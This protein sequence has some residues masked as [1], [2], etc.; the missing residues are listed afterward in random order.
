MSFPTSPT[1]GQQVIIG[2]RTWRWDGSVWAVVEPAA[3]PT[4]ALLD[5]AP[6]ISTPE[7][8]VPGNTVLDRSAYPE[9]AE[10]VP[11]SYD[12]TPNQVNSN[13]TTTGKWAGNRYCRSPNLMAFWRG[14]IYEA[15][16]R[17]LRGLVRIDYPIVDGVETGANVTNGD[18][19]SVGG[20]EGAVLL[21]VVN[22]E[23]YLITSAAQIF[24]KPNP[25][26][27]WVKVGDLDLS[28]LNGG[29][30]PTYGASL[31]CGYLK[32]GKL[33]VGWKFRTRTPNDR[34]SIGISR[35]DGITTGP[36]EQIH[37]IQGSSTY[38]RE[39]GGVYAFGP[40]HEGHVS[41]IFHNVEDAYSNN[42]LDSRVVP[43][44]DLSQTFFTSSYSGIAWV[45]GLRV[46]VSARQEG[47]GDQF[48]VYDVDNRQQSNG[49]MSNGHQFGDGSSL[50]GICFGY[51]NI[52]AFFNDADNYIYWTED[53]GQTWERTSRSSSPATQ[54]FYQTP[55]NDTVVNMP[56][57]GDLDK[58]NGVLLSTEGTRVW[59]GKFSSFDP[60]QS[61]LTPNVGPNKIIKV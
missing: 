19:P 25:D 22:D 57:I 51:D 48:I 23:L 4:G 14:D 50:P 29:V 33:I 42:Y 59:W 21:E 46:Y 43:I 15:G 52:A 40:A 16:Y 41:M 44:E 36:A 27:P 13:V 31:T 9:L 5:T 28:G 3:F 49:S 17:N 61:F 60:T 34:A 20:R 45:P 58:L 53:A 30:A 2:G 35:Y 32:E 12:R 37:E 1:I 24:R 56:V 47:A 38:T 8:W 55:T 54:G 39:Y 18:W 26:D 6:G 11:S 7:G 10:V